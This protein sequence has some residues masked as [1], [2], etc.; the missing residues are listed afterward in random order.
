M[1]RMRINKNGIKIARPGHDVDT[2]A[3]K[4][5]FFSSTGV[6][7][8]VYQ[9]NLVTVSDYSGLASDRYLRARV[10]FS[11]GFTRPP[12]VFAAGLRVDGGA[13]V[14]PVV[15]LVIGTSYARVHPHYS[16]EID[17]T[18]FWIYVPKSI[19]ENIPVNVPTTWRYW[20]LDNV[21]DT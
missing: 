6:A 10:N 1:P 21:L 13:D 3:E 18:G 9:T 2:A 20:V 19:P 8:R 16:L 4:D 15:Y 11:K 12:A 5:M 7:A 17:T 14:T